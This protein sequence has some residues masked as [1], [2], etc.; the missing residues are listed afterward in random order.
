MKIL[1]RGNH[2]Y[3]WT[4]LAKLEQLCQTHQLSSLKF[5]R[6]N[7][8]L[9]GDSTIICGSRGWI[10]PDDPAFTSDDAGS[11][12][13]DRATAPVAPGSQRNRMPWL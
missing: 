13:G 6:N 4:S 7:A 3:W 8:L 12:P 10:L 1:S 2:D 5:M 11:M 9:I